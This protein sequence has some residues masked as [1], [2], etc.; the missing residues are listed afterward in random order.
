MWNTASVRWL[1]I[2]VPLYWC[3]ST[4]RMVSVDALPYGRQRQDSSIRNIGNCTL[5]SLVP[6]Q[7][8]IEFQTISS[9]DILSYG[10]TEYLL[11]RTSARW[12]QLSHSASIENVASTNIFGHNGSAVVSTEYGRMSPALLHNEQRIALTDPDLETVL[13]EYYNRAIDPYHGNMFVRGIELLMESLPDAVSPS[14]ESSDSHGRGLPWYTIVIASAGGA[15][16]CASVMVLVLIGVITYRQYWKDQLKLWR[17]NVERAR[18]LQL[19]VDDGGPGETTTEGHAVVK[20]EEEEP[21]EHC[22]MIMTMN[23]ECTDS[24]LPPQPPSNDAGASEEFTAGD[25]ISRSITAATT[26]D[27]TISSL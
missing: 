2:G 18:D 10:L 16:A 1:F 5:V 22:R 17:N 25:N 3:I 21:N 15:A 13:Q 19:L 26:D 4:T 9:P 8:S 12:I 20:E 14:P 27:R 11:N 24:C 23:V 6:F 7:I